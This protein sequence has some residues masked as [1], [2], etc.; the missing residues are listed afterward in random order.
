MPFATLM[1]GWL[2]L[3]QTATFDPLPAETAPPPLVPVERSPTDFGQSPEDAT[4]DAADPPATFG[5]LAPE[6]LPGGSPVGAPG[7]YRFDSAPTDEETVEPQSPSETPLAP[8]EAAQEDPGRSPPEMVAQALLLPA[9]GDLVGQPVPLL[10]VLSS[11]ADRRRQMEATQAYWD[12]VEAVGVYRF[13]FD[14][15][16][17][18]QQL[19]PSQGEAAM[20]EAA[21]ASSTAGLREAELAATARQYVLT[22]LLISPVEQPLPLPADPPHVG[23][24]KTHFEKIFPT[25]WAPDRA[26]LI[27]RTLPILF[28]A[29]DRRAAAVRAAEAAA[30]ETARAYREGR[31]DLA[32][33]VESLRH[34]RQQRQSLLAAACRYNHQ[35]A[36]YA[37]TIAAPG[38]SSQA[39]LGMLI[40]SSSDRPRPLSPREGASSSEPEPASGV[41][42]TSHRPQSWPS[43]P[44]LAPQPTP[45]VRPNQPT[46]AVRPN[47][48]TPA[49]RPKTGGAAEAVSAQSDTSDAW[50][51]SASPDRNEP[52]PAAPRELIPPAAPTDEP[53]QAPA[54]EPPLL[55]L[56]RSEPMDRQ[57]RRMP[58]INADVP[59]MRRLV[60][61]P[62]AADGPTT[63]SF[64]APADPADATT[65]VYPGLVDAAPWR[66][67]KELAAMTHWQGT[68]PEG[69]G[70]PVDLRSCLR[71]SPGSRRQAVIVAYWTAN[72]KAAEY[73]VQSQKLA[74]VESLTAALSAGNA[75]SA[76]AM[77][78]WRPLAAEADRQEAL[79]AL[80]EAQFVLARQSGRLAQADWPLPST[81]PYAGDYAMPSDRSPTWPPAPG[82]YRRIRRMLPMLAASVAEHATA[83]VK[84]DTARAEAEAACLRGQPAGAAIEQIDR[85][86]DATLAFLE[87]LSDYNK[88]IGEYVLLTL[89][90]NTPAETLV[91]ALLPGR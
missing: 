81:P 73:Q 43:R 16:R 54:L 15:D 1:L 29:I 33:V 63:A 91:A 38:T 53:A 2:V 77:F 56:P 35:I 3:G 51:P 19:Q 17:Q 75:S 67:A 23:P 40:R 74:A 71:S 68:L 39:L 37:L 59:S 52:S 47:Q 6:E 21:R 89:P 60:R 13:A 70:E 41:E 26:R 66:Q 86:T 88:A 42:P 8:D 76:D 46:R 5:E 28:R 44:S 79:A 25:R 80:V 55:P 12:L 20:L 83:V 30:A 72:Q 64:D 34:A 27:D 69:L 45:A 61:K 85:Q 50:G 78:G 10:T 24:Y 7:E 18:L 84:A 31:A 90:P 57:S 36:E 65:A 49:V 62:Q 4:S 48:P 11:A 87:T 22:G 32:D 82:T 14:Y 58:Q 9:E